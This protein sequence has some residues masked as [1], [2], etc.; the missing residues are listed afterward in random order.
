MEK[1][2]TQLYMRHMPKE[3]NTL[4]ETSCSRDGGGGHYFCQ[5]PMQVALQ[6]TEV[7]AI[8]IV[9]FAV[10]AAPSPASASGAF[11][12]RQIKL[13]VPSFQQL[14][15]KAPPPEPPCPDPTCPGTAGRSCRCE[16]PLSPSCWRRQRVKQ[17]KS[18]LPSDAQ[19]AHG[20]GELRVCHTLSPF[21]VPLGNLQRL[22]MLVELL[23]AGKLGLAELDEGA[24]AVECLS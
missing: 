11:R 2:G 3:N 10:F 5:L 7:V 21:V 15:A 13:A 6:G 19:D 18:L 24:Q 14:H 4:F 20:L 23:D 22:R 17:P 16:L 9:V 1:L 12:G 8:T